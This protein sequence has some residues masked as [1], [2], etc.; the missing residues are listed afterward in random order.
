MTQKNISVIWPNDDILKSMTNLIMPGIPRY[1]PA[2]LKPYFGHDVTYTGATL[3]EVANLLA[4]IENKIIPESE[5]ILLTNDKI[6]KILSITGTQVEALERTKTKHD[7]RALV[8]II[9]EIVGPEIGKWIHVPLTSYDAL[10][11]GRAY[12]YQLAYKNVIDPSIRSTVKDL[13]FMV[14]KYS[15]VKQ[16][17]RT[18]GQHALPITIG[19]WF[20]TILF[21]I[22]SNLIEMNRHY[23]ELRGKISGA[24][25]AYNAQEHL[26]FN[27]TTNFEACVLEY[28]GMKPSLISTQILPPEPSARFLHDIVLTSGSIAQFG[29]D[30]R[31]L[32]RTEISEITEPF[33]EDQ[34][35]SSTMA[36]KR[37]P[38]SFEN[39]EGMYLMSKNIYGN[40]FDSIISEHQRDLTGSS[41]LRSLPTIPVNLQVQLNTLNRLDEGTK[42]ISFLKQIFINENSCMRN[43]EMSAHTVLGEPIYIALQM[44]GYTGDAHKLVNKILMKIASQNN[45]SLMHALT[46]YSQEDEKVAEATANIPDEVKSL[47]ANPSIY[48]GLAPQKAN[49][50][51]NWAETTLEQII[52]EK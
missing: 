4:L 1:Q 39:M 16:I 22:V 2:Q 37:N 40:V 27:K 24:V 25:G 20:A 11:T 26:G 9:Q 18:H 17:G 35:G 28:L 3:V 45:T 29:R 15:G 13:L 19:F 50:I 44:A 36:N 51:A 6:H 52:I 49:E 21:R 43:L 8:Q 38:I 48:I 41:L 34:A 32:M 33:S 14:R 47:L 42:S 5:A 7:I 30:C 10:D 23:Q 46:L 12:M 31:H